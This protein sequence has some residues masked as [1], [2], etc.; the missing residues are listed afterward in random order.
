LFF[1]FQIFDRSSS[2]ADQR[3]RDDGRRTAFFDVPRGEDA[4]RTLAVLSTPPDGRYN[5]DMPSPS[6]DTETRARLKHWIDNW[7]RVSPLLEAERLEALRGLDDPE[8]ARIARDLVWPMGTLGS[9]R[10]GDDGAG[11]V[12]MKDALRQLGAR[13]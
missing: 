12:R 7:R 3:G 13:R 9:D 8:P 11:L 5:S 2:I 6:I 4:L 1:V 10:G